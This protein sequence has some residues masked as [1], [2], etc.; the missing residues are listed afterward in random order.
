MTAKAAGGNPSNPADYW[1][2]RSAGWT[3][4]TALGRATDDRFN[5][6][7]IEAAGIVPDDDVLDLAAGTGDPAVTIAEHLAG[8]GSVTAFDMTADMLAVAERRAASLGLANMRTRIG[9]MADLPFADES[10]DAVTCRN[11]LMF[12]EDRIV[13]VREARRVLKPGGR[14]VW[15]VWATFEENPT[16]GAVSRGLEAYFGEAFPPRMVR[17]ALGVDGALTAVL[18]AAGFNW[19][20]ESVL[21]H[22]RLVGPGDAYFRRAAGRTIPHRTDRLD[23]AGWSA[24]TAAIEDAASAMRDGD[25]FAI[26]VVMRLGVGEK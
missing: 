8:T 19:I 14:A 16:F 24:L 1:K 3:E 20:E 15:L 2:N 21:S 23:E 11:G 10:F 7:L 26:P 9:D 6:A 22:T 5:R 4:G 17:H 13:C 25:K 18:R 12:P